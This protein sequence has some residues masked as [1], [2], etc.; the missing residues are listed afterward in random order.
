MKN[1]N[2]NKDEGWTE[3][4]RE[5][6]QLA[7]D[8]ILEAEQRTIAE[9]EAKYGKAIVA[10]NRTK[11]KLHGLVAELIKLDE[12]QE[13]AGK[14]GVWSEEMHRVNDRNEKEW[15]RLTREFYV[16]HGRRYEAY[17]REIADC[18]ARYKELKALLLP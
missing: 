8:L 12:G 11:F 16:K 9:I 3:Y 13:E 6:P 14:P 10:Y 1:R 17:E 2:R 15:D 18:K 4:L 5:N 7:E